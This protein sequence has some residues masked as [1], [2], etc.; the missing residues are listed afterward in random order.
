[1]RALARLVP[2]SLFG[3]AVLTLVFTFGLFAL[4]TFGAVVYYALAPVARR[5]TEDLAA[6]MVL[7]ARSLVQLPASLHPD[8][9][10]KLDQDY[11]LR[12]VEGPNAPPALHPYFFPYVRRLELALGERMGHPVK[13][14]S[15]LTDGKRWFWVDLQSDGRHVWAGFPRDR[16]HTRPLEA[17]L[18]LLITAVVFVVLTAAM[19]A[20]RVT[21]PLERLSR[22]AEQ[23]ARGGSPA[24]LPE[25]GPRELASLA[26]QLNE[27]SRQVRELLADRTVLLAGISHDLRTPLTRLRLA[28]EML[29][30]DSDKALTERMERDLDEMNALIAQAIELGKTLGAGE[31]S[32]VDIG[33]LLG[34]LAAG[35]PRV[36]W[37]PE[38]PC[39]HRVN[40][41]ALRRILGNLVENALRYSR[42][43]VELHLD[44]EHCPPVIFVLDRGPGIPEDER[45]AVFR[46]FYRL[47]HSRS[48]RTGGSGLGLAVARQLAIAND[49]EIHLGARHGGGT[50]ASVYLP[51]AGGETEGKPE[52][53]S[54]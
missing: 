53:E 7:S 23:M 54:G 33:Q 4:V 21:A 11:G 45:E 51:P 22:M 27:T 43:Q 39:R 31:R 2:A 34:D 20:R 50:V 15:N 52:C 16:I 26:H 25:T 40:E 14:L 49:I 17:V 9:L 12:L 38:P 1:V 18:V 36:V 30:G 35:R 42:G 8:Y 46:P 48:R 29:S 44:C 41:L 19:L 47:E 37:T 28:L 5:S 13:I 6:F 3:R 32:I 10:A 24:P